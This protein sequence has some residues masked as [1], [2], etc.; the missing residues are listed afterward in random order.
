M[1]ERTKYLTEA[2]LFAPAANKWAFDT[3]ILNSNGGLM[4]L[5]ANANLSDITDTVNARINLGLRIGADVQPYNE[6]LTAYAG[7]STPT[8]FS[9]TAMGKSTASEWRE[10]I[11]AGT[12]RSVTISGGSTGLIFTNGTTT[13][14]GTS[15]L[16]GVL[17]INYGGTGTTSV[18]GLRTVLGINNV[19]NTSDANKPMS[20]ATASAL[21]GKFD[22]PIGSISQYIRG[23]GTLAPFPVLG[24]E[25]GTVTSI[26]LTGGT[27]GLSFDNGTITTSGTAALTG[28]LSINSGGTGVSTLAELRSLLT[29][30]NVDNTSD[31]NKPISTATQTAL[32]R[33]VRIPASL[34][35]GQTLELPPPQAGKV[36]G[37]NDLGNALINTNG[38][39][40]GNTLPAAV[41]IFESDGAQVQFTLDN[42]PGSIDNISVTIGGVSQTP[43]INY[44]LFGSIV[45]LQE[46]A[47]LDEIIVIRS[48]GSF[49]FGDLKANQIVTEDFT[50]G[51]IPTDSDVQEALQALE[52]ATTRKVNGP[53][54]LGTLTL[55]TPQA[56]MAIG[57]N[58]SATSLINIAPGTGGGG[59]DVGSVY[60][61]TDVFTGN[62]TD[63]EFALSFVP[64]SLADISVSVGGIDQVP[65]VSYTIGEGNVL[66][67]PEPVP[68][69]AK[70][71]VRGIRATSIDIS[72]L[73]A[74]RVEKFTSVTNQ[75]DYVLEY[76]PLNLDEIELS[77]GGNI[78]I[79]GDD[80]T[81]I[82]PNIV[83][84]T[85]APTGGLPILIRYGSHRVFE[86]EANAG[87]SYVDRFLG[88]GLTT[89]FT[90][91]NNPGSL[92][93]LL[94]IVD[95]VP[96]KPTDDYLLVDDVTLVFTF[97]VVDG[98][99]I[100]VHYS[101]RLEIGETV[102]SLVK[103]DPFVGSLIPDGSNVQEAIQI[104]ETNLQRV[105]GDLFSSETGDGSSKIAYPDP[106]SAAYLK[107]VSDVINGLPV[108]VMRFIPGEKILGIINRTN[109]DNLTPYF[110][111]ALSSGV[112]ELIVPA[113]RFN[114]DT[115]IAM[116]SPDQMLKGA[117]SR[118][119]EFI[120]RS[121][122]QPGITLANGVA[123]YG[124][125]GIKLSRIGVPVAGADGIKFLGTTD[126][127]SLED[128]WVEG[129][130]NNL[131]IGT[132]DTG[133]I[134]KLRSSKALNDGVVQTNAINYG[135]S[136]WDVDHVLIDRCVRDGWRIQ[137]TNGPAG[138]ILGQMRNI[139]SFANSGY[140]INLLGSATT[141]IYDF[142]ISDAFMGSDGLGSI[143]L[144]TFGGKHRI[145]GFFERNGEDA[146]GPNVT[147]PASRLGVGIDATG[148]NSDIL[149]YGSLI[150]GNSLDGIQHDGS[151]LT[152]SA[153]HIFD[154]GRASVASR[155]S[156]ILSH[157]GSL[158][159]SGS[160][161]R[162]MVGNTTQLYGISAGHD[163]V[164]ISG[165]DLSNNTASATTLSG[166]AKAEVVANAGVTV[167]RIAGGLAVGSPTG[168]T[169]TGDINVTTN[170]KKNGTVYT[171][172]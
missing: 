147:T 100:V 74:A 157:S 7:G 89:E 33:R 113:G 61:Y 77:I 96:Q 9:L 26:T 118:R 151:V 93:N 90:L 138:L 2:T 108:S 95:G 45:T 12:V 79:P 124:I 160:I 130:W 101:D 34:P 71:I 115:A 22:R 162:N 127:T 141:G 15:T 66:V 155:R 117:G 137:S 84:F 70:I 55:P 21:S 123:G 87:V 44:T 23:D 161:V 97:T 8:P 140:G 60:S 19:D 171:N 58:P 134:F 65:E 114:L 122:S 136:Q 168:T 64:I 91:S 18:N 14:S 156:G 54:S 47:P 152:V 154:N 4:L 29:I 164:V 133:H 39:G 86:L 63:S 32:D 167:N 5:R 3:G 146:T 40:G 112:R 128:I 142:R 20:N 10:F 132:C 85:P 110:Q 92:Y 105:E 76:D 129:H 83:R 17:S 143:N 126:D 28:I 119:C 144:K 125:S 120:I 68:D 149:I 49:N 150:D 37:W 16:S 109:T 111:D 1:A 41:D 51:I 98:A 56:G 27:T 82:P 169:L 94:V 50:G 11:G 46:P 102:A 35:Q 30:N 159:V 81:F 107:T 36:I 42:I 80:Y 166:F 104:L 78:Q 170:L 75:T 73:G 103:T 163:N 165:N 59:G 53:T 121:T 43:G 72:Q 57:W 172:P 148:S 135:P 69:T 88:N 99:S 31:V 116:S 158:V 62:G 24:D 153:S 52:T 38:G 25:I 106:V 48:F 145:S 139:K 13:D 6:R 131:V 67:F